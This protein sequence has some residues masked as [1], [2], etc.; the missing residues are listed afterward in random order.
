MLLLL[1]GGALLP[2]AAVASDTESTSRLNATAAGA[3]NSYAGWV[4]D[5]YPD[6]SAADLLQAF[7]RMHDAGANLVWLGHSNPVDVDPNAH[8]VGLSYAVYAA[9]S[10]PSDPQNSA[11]L[12][13]IAAQRRAL[14]AARAVGLK[15]VLPVGYR[16][17]MGP[18]WNAAH[19]DSLRRGPDGSILNFGGEDASPYAG[20]FRNDT[21]QYYQWVEQQFVAPYRDVILMVMLSNEPTGVD[22]SSASDAAFYGRYGYHFADV[23]IDPNRVTQLGDFQSHVMVE[24]TVWAARQWAVIDAGL[25]VTLA[26]DGSPGRNNMQAPALEDIFREAPANL[27]PAWDTNFR[28]GAPTDALN[29]A[30]IAALDIFLGTLGHFSAKYGRPYWLWSSGNS[31]GLS[32][33]SADPSTIADALVNLQMVADV[34]RQAG[35]VLRGVAIWAYNVR[36]QGLY[37]DAYHPP[38][39]QDDLFSRLTG[40]LPAVRKILDG[41]AGPGP[42]VYVVA[43]N[44]MPDRLLGAGRVV[45]IWAFRGYNF[46][47]LVSIA[48]SGV[49]MAVVNTLAGENLARTRMLIVLARDPNDLSEADLVAIRGYR[50]R[51]GVLVDASTVDG[52]RNFNAQWVSPGNAPELFFADSYP[53]S[54]PSPVGALGLP[55][56]VNSFVVTGPSELIAYGGTSGDDPDKMKA[57]VHLPFR[58]AVTQFDAAGGGGVVREVGPGLVAIPTVRHTF[59]LLPL[60][61]ALSPQ[62]HDTHYFTE[63]GYRVDDSAIWNYFQHRGGVRTFGYPTSRTITFLGFRTQFF[64]REIVQLAADGSPR[65]LNL[66]DTGLLPYTSF[67]D[68]SFPAP[69]PDLISTAPTPDSATYGQDAIQW[70]L[71]HA[72]NTW[73]GLPVGFGRTFLSAVSLSDAFPAGGGDSSLLPLLNLEIWGLPTSAPAYDPNNHNFVYMR[74]QRGIMHYDAICNCTQGILLADYLKALLLNQGVPADL[75][76]E[77][78]GS[79][80]FGQ[81]DPIALDWLS[82][83]Q[84]LPGTDLSNAFERG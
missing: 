4:M 60:I 64:Q 74:F 50:A 84:L 9:A 14:D 41:P 49:T 40:S 37:N 5:A 63:T 29:D 28:N 8:E 67:N 83:P 54:K 70:A 45:D 61:Q 6:L 34:S 12:S 77:A 38:Y 44:A 25:T 19:K 57:W 3:T 48:R 24:Y 75:A 79:P 23:G 35:G 66:L 2:S 18:T 21:V 10:N 76:G 46:G 1:L 65:T 82:H 31:W 47:S 58:V 81:Y 59:A 68:S 42:D 20:D 53:E 16:T 13:I 73:H 56:L 80:F 33:G 36:G 15:L 43:P 55:N 69:D 51:G 26:F 27:Q 71:Q 52:A 22:Y 62:V 72:P 39:S 32:G 78:A 11:A 30:D 17:Q 7:T